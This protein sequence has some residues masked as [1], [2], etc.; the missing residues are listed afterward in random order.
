[1]WRLVLAVCRFEFD[2]C[3]VLVVARLLFEL[4]RI[5]RFVFVVRWSPFAVC[6]SVFVVRRVSVVVVVFG[7]CCVCCVVLGGFVCGVCW[8]L[9]VVGRCLV[10]VV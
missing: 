4:C 2:V 7:R 10:F 3:C 9:C 1:M 5:C 6:W 8:S